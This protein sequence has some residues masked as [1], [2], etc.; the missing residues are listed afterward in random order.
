MRTLNRPMFRMGGPIKEGIMHGIREPKRNGGPTGTGLV[1]DQRYPKT[2]GREHHLLPLAP[3]FWGAARMAARPFGQYLMRNVPA[4][5]RL[6]T[7]GKGKNLRFART[8][9]QPTKFAPDPNKPRTL[10]E[11]VAQ[12]RYFKPNW[13]GRQIKSDPLYA[14]VAGGTTM[15][16]RGAKWLGQKAYGL[17]KYSLTTPS[18]LAL[19]AASTYPF[20]PDGTPKDTDTDVVD[21]ISVRETG[22]PGGGDKGMK[23]TGAWFQKEAKLAK[24]KLAI[25]NREKQTNKL[26]KMMGYDESKKDA[27][28]DALIDASKIISSRGTLDK[29]NITAEL[30][31]P[32]IEATSKRFDKPKEIKEAVGLLQTKTELEKE[33]AAAKGDASTQAI[34]ALSAASGRSPKYVANAKL[35]IANSAAEAKAQLAKVKT[36]PITSD[37]VAAVI[38]QYADENGIPF[39]Q[40]ITTEQKNEKVGKGKEYA[41]VVDLI[42]ALELDTA[43]SDDGLYVVGT[44]IVEVVN[45]IPKLKG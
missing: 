26:L 41:T 15:A 3:L 23:G 39:K 29:K 27:A 9:K 21:E 43:G 31:N 4:M 19:T 33:L 32:I 11:N 13:L 36:N 18:G 20:W 5:T 37:D 38:S 24:E 8:K 45:G 7:L 1:G 25:E 2:G 34:A 28:Y 42:N 17:G 30:I 22:V 6:K 12:E 40:Q 16:G 10:V 44:S 35:G 14:S